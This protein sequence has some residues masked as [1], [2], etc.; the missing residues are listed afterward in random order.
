MYCHKE[1][2][3]ESFVVVHR[4]RIAALAIHSLSHECTKFHRKIPLPQPTSAITT[5]PRTARDI[6]SNP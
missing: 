1:Q 5:P 2:F 6:F 4:V 3:I